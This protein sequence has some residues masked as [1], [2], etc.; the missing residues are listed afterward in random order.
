M[1]L[2]LG[3]KETLPSSSKY[4]DHEPRPKRPIN[5]LEL[6]AINTKPLENVENYDEYSIIDLGLLE[7]MNEQ[8]FICKICNKGSVVV[9]K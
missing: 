5:E 8:A 9:K 4:N 2:V 3:Q 6:K 1:D 7:E